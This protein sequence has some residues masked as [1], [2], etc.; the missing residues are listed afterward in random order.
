LPALVD[1]AEEAVTIQAN[2]RQMLLADSYAR[3]RPAVSRVIR[4]SMSLRHQFFAV[5]VGCQSGSESALK[6]Q[7][8]YTIV[9]M[10][11]RHPVSQSSA[12][13]H[14][15]LAADTYDLATRA[16]SLIPQMKTSYGDRSFSALGPTVW[17]SLP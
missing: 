9:F 16:S 1:K 12:Q 14:P 5:S 17:N 8:L 11:W 4:Q 15:T 7:L 2:E 6:R 3:W 13:W 10:A